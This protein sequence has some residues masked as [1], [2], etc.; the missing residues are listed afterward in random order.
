L[1]RC[2]ERLPF[3]ERGYFA[4]KNWTTL[5]PAAVDAVSGYRGSAALP[6]GDRDCRP[7][8]EA[9]IGCIEEMNE[10]VTIFGLAAATVGNMREAF[11]DR[12]R[13]LLNTAPHD[14]AVLKNVAIATPHYREA[15]A[16]ISR[17]LEGESLGR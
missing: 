13:M 5:P 7:V 17:G 15:F 9:T 4:A 11:G 2:S 1:T 3:S 6:D 10:P 16:P 12:M 8:I 14:K